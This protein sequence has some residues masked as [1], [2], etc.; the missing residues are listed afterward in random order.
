MRIVSNRSFRE[1]RKTVSFSVTFFSRKFRCL[2]DTEE[3]Y[4]RAGEVTDVYVYNK[5]GA[6]SLHVG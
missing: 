6:S 3:E 4:G 2:W 5:Y 1:N